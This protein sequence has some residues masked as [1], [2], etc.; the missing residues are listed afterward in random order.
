MHALKG[1]KQKCVYLYGDHVGKN[2]QNYQF[3]VFCSR[4]VFRYGVIKFQVFRGL[5]ALEPPPPKLGA[6]GVQ[7]GPNLSF[8]NV[9]FSL[10]IHLF[11]YLI[12]SYFPILLVFDE[13]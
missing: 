1:Q 9:F 8:F 12:H 10:F 13:C 11:I 3:F 4:S 6:K 7:K 5:S 2:G